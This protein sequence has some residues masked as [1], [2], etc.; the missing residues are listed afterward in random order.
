MQ[1]GHADVQGVRQEQ[2]HVRR[3]QRG[4]DFLN[5]YAN[6]DDQIQS[7]TLMFGA[8]GVSLHV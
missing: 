3:T 7:M 4:P 5:Q 1:R 6:P 2:I 8:R